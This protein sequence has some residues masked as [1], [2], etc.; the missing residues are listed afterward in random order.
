LKDS[1]Y[2]YIYST[3]SNLAA[4][5]LLPELVQIG[6]ETNKGILLSQEVNDAGWSLDWARNSVLFNGA[7]TAV[8]DIESDYSADIQ[9]ALHI[10]NPDDVTWFIQ[11]FWNHG[12]RDFDIIGISYYRQFHD[13]EFNSVGNIISNLVNTYPGKEVMIFE[14]AYP[15]T[16]SNADGANNILSAS[17]PGYSPLTVQHQKEWL[18]DLTQAV[19][20][21]GGSGVIYW[22]PGWVSTACETLY[23]TGSNWENATFFNFNDQLQEEGGIGWMLYGYQFPTAV[24]EGVDLSGGI[25]II[26]VG[27][28]IIIRRND[29][30]LLSRFS[31][32]N[33]FNIE[34]KKIYTQ[35]ENVMWQDYVYSFSVPGLSG[36]VY[37][38]TAKTD[39]GIV[40]G[41]FL[42][43]E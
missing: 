4:D 8:R 16:T 7:I 19:I 36:G 22:E 18:I 13:V 34:G 28:E 2:N 10:A 24:N 38:I 39:D 20:D 43:S 30:G 35:G 23:G 26:C 33:L 21:H 1:L 12:V 9:V 17:F 40:S 32:I 5:N 11:Q 14:T 25:K 41:F 31:E 6:N 42:K 3:L 15:W 37:L 27:D 29:G